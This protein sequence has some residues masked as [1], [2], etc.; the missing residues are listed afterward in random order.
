MAARNIWPAC[1]WS[2]RSYPDFVV[3]SFTNWRDAPDQELCPPAQRR[4]RISVREFVDRAD[5]SAA[6]ALRYEPKKGC[7]LSRTCRTLGVCARS[8]QCHRGLVASH[9]Q[10][11]ARNERHD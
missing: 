10:R 7:I 8:A 5:R 9:H 4:S 1:A 11:L 6:D 2:A 3:D